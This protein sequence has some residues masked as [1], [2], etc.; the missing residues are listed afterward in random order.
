M[1]ENP[2]PQVPP[3]DPDQP[4][5]ATP[6]LR[7]TVQGMPVQGRTPD[8]QTQVML[9]LGDR[10]QLADRQV[11]TSP[12][13][14]FMLPH[15]DGANTV[16]TIAE[17]SVQMAQQQPNVP[18]EAIGHITEANVQALVAQLDHAGLIEGPTFDA[19]VEKMRRAFDESDTL[20]PA[21]TAAI[22]D[23][24][25]EQAVGKEEATDEK[26]AELGPDRLREAMDEWMNKAV[27]NAEHPAFDTLPKV[28]F[29]PHLDYWRGW[30]N[31]A[32]VYARLRVVDRPARVVVLGT[33]HFGRGTGVVG[34]DKGYES[35]LGVSPF[36]KPFADLLA[37]HLG[38][39]DTAKLYN[40]KYDHERE[41]SI[42]LHIPWVQH[43]FGADESGAYPPVFAAL[44]HDPARNNGEAYD[45]HGLGLQPFVD[46]LKAAINDAPGKTLIVSSCDL[47]HVGRSF[48]DQQPLMGD[49]EPAK[50]FRDKVIGHDREM[51]EL[52]KQAKSS[53]LIA[54]MAWQQ[55]PTR[56]CSVGNM[57]AAMLATDAESVEVYNHAAAADP[58]GH[59]MVSSFAGAVV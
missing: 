19:L 3:F 13:A 9:A 52:V 2:T 5:H 11:V 42:E 35:P 40:E 48:G 43:V 12:L 20:P 1:A 17:K 7:P 50:A 24:L 14:Q 30:L 55:N 46:A 18:D 36:D 57:V 10:A 25:V 39:D 45:A 15:M 37:Q 51:L 21:S 44:V 26:K 56:W 34:C 41:H 27:E 16:P 49:E 33:N 32:S 47:S 23:A 38:D 59:A 29:A 8:G 6:K 53:E 22:A 58:Q 28:I 54:S 31:Y 4:H